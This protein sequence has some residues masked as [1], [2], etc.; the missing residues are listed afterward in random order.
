MFEHH[1][2]I[3]PF[4]ILA[5]WIHVSLSPG[6]AVCWKMIISFSVLPPPPRK[7]R[8]IFAD[9]LTFC[10][11]A[12][13]RRKRKA[14]SEDSEESTTM[15]NVKRKAPAKPTEANVAQQVDRQAPSTQ[16]ELEVV[17]QRQSNHGQELPEPNYGPGNPDAVDFRIWCPWRDPD[18]TNLTDALGMAGMFRLHI[19]KLVEEEFIIDYRRD[20]GHTWDV[21]GDLNEMVAE[22]RV[23]DED[24]PVPVPLASPW[25]PKSRKLLEK[26]KNEMQAQLE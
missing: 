2:W 15:A 26:I 14:P 13:A 4:D 9:P 11:M 17:F 3:Q 8:P 16:R 18:L 22:W 10:I 5:K 25:F 19:T 6:S 24:W 20:L 7:E 21:E 1:C 23:R 12:P